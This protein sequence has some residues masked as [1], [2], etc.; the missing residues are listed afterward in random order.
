MTVLY[1]HTFCF[2]RLKFNIT[3]HLCVNFMLLSRTLLWPLKCPLMR[4]VQP[5]LGNYEV[6][7][8]CKAIRRV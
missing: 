7:R 1:T 6:V 2:Y 8:H 5:E 4:V 3:L